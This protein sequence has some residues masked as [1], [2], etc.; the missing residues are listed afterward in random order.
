M[1][2]FNLNLLLRRLTSLV[3]TA[4]ASIILQTLSH[5]F[6]SL[7]ASVSMGPIY[8]I[9]YDNLTI[10]LRSSQNAEKHDL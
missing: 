10:I 6:L 7:L 2:F 5:H 3:K 8:K 1:L 4:S 9:F